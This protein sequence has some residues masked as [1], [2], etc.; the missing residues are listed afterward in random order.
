MRN[1][2]V[3]VVTDKNILMEGLIYM[4]TVIVII[5]TAVC[6]FTLGYIVKEVILYTIIKAKKADVQI[7]LAR[8]IIERNQTIFKKEK[9]IDF[10]I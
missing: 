5:L 2:V 4:I 7:G 9:H 10:T 6:F 3:S 8:K 1:M